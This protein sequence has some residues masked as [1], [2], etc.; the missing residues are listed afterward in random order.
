MRIWIDNTGLH[1]AARCLEGRASPSHEYEI[2]S[3][4]QLATLVIFGTKITLNGFEDESLAQRSREMLRTLS[5]YGISEDIISIQPTTEA[6][7]AL[8]C[9]TATESSISDLE[10]TF[11]PAEYELL[12]VAPP[13]AR[14]PYMTVKCHT[15]L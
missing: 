2:R 6:E 8:A 7:Y 1:T 12:G 11:N 9:K 3:L 10:E 14:G 13:E 15:Y 5:G 4:L